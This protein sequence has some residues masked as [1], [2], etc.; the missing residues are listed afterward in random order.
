MKK[1][2]IFI[3]LFLLLA[4]PVWALGYSKADKIGKT[5]PYSAAKTPEDLAKY[6]MENVQTPTDRARALASW[7][8]YQMD[9]DGYR[10]KIIKQSA[11]Q[12]RPAPQPLPNNPFYSRIGTAQE[13]A[14]L[15]QK[16]GTLMGLDVVTISGYAGKSVP[17]SADAGLSATNMAVRGILRTVSNNPLNY[18]MQPY[19]ASWNAVKIDDKW[20][21]VDTYWMSRGGKKIGTTETQLGMEQLIKSREK[22]LPHLSDLTA[23]KRYDETFFF[24]D[25]NIFIKTHYPLD[26]KWQLLRTPVS[27][28]EFTR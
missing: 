17:Y 18:K 26:E 2:G 23:G 14:D 25:P 9:Q 19:E 20:K 11:V 16:I 13:Y 12:N 27:W 1:W 3:G 4:Q 15:Y 5:A 28:R 21:L 6:I 22:K 24:A 8:V 7:M 10:V